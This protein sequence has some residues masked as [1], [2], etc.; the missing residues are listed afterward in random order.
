L[1]FFDD[2]DE[3]RTTRRR[4][5]RSAPSGP[6]RG[7]GG[8]PEDRQV[9]RRRQAVALGVALLLLI[10]VILGVKS[11]SDSS[12]KNHLRDYNNGVA[13]IVAKSDSDVG[14]PLFALLSGAGGGRTTRALELQNQV[15]GLKLE[16]EQQLKRAEDLDVPSQATDA[17]RYVLLALELRRDG[18]AT[19]ARFLQPALSNTDNGAAVR[20]IAGEMRAFDA[21]DVIWSQ[22]V[23]PTL[24]DDLTSNGV[25]VGAGGVTVPTSRF[26]TDLGWLDPTFVS[27]RLGA[28]TTGTGGKP[29]PGSHGHGLLSTSVGSTTLSSTATNR[30]PASPAPIF[31]VKLQNQGQNDET[32]VRVQVQVTGSGKPLSATKTIPSTAAGQM[33]TA[34]VSLPRNPPTGSVVTVKVTVLPVPGEGTTTNNTASYPVLFTSS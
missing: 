4:P 17:Q 3:P 20:R 10:L 26:L 11:C 1:S 13:A 34:S 23:I 28:A 33:A 22:R 5:G 8:P 12:R 21:S 14:R 24:R 31:Q 6:R 32:N 15:D 16:A 18:V 30:I 27:S 29:K 7:R 25:S 2:A 19:I 9:I